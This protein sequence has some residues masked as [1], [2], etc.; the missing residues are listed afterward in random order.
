MQT[1]LSD[2]TRNRLLAALPPDELGRL[3][4]D[5]EPVTLKFAEILAERGEPIGHVYFPT[6]CAIV[7]VTLLDDHASLEVG[8]VG[9]EGVVG[10]ALVLDVTVSSQRALVQGPGGA[11][12]MEAGLF[13]QALE[14]SRALRYLLKRYVHAV[15]VQLAQ[16]A[17]CT[18]FH[19]VEARLARWLLMTQDRARS[20][21][22]HVTHEF[23]A[24]VL[25]VRRVGITRAATTLQG[26][27]LI[28]YARGNVAIVD[29]AG[30][31][32]AACG[33]YAAD[34][35]SYAQSLTIPPKARKA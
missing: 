1:A 28:R 2:A 22:F 30:L 34:K 33:C 32:A 31:E 35:L 7:L 23:L 18:R 19:V 21:S 27:G 14:R 16:T 25:G 13:R 26:R 15:M 12:R 11:V 10:T 6:D 9:N 24:Q 29:R 8:L 4:D 5:C 20:D 3:L 17:G